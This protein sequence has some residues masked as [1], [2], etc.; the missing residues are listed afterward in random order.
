MACFNGKIV[1]I[2]AASP[3]GLGG[4][5][6]L[7]HLRVILASIGTFVLPNQVAVGNAGTNLSDDESVKDDNLNNAV[8][9]QVQ[10]LARVIRGLH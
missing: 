1:G 3:G 10:E 4:L 6:G 5:R 2:M 9:N 7:H 8:Q